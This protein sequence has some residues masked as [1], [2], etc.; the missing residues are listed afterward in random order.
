[1]LTVIFLVVNALLVS[2]VASI[3]VMK[4]RA[5]VGTTWQRS[6]IAAHDSAVMLWQYIV[7]FAADIL[8]WSEKGAEALNLP[9]VQQFLTAYVT[10]KMLAGVVAGIA[11]ITIVARLRTLLRA[12]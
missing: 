8:A 12:A 11:V 3:F 7:L 2:G 5:A 1:M 4:Y 10:P 6:V 9:E